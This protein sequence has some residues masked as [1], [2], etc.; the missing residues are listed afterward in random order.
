MGKKIRGDQQITSA[1]TILVVDDEE[2][3]LW[4][5]D[6]MLQKAGYSVIQA[7]NGEKVLKLLE[8]DIPDLILMDYRL[9]NRNG[10]QVAADVKQRIPTVPIIML[11]GY[12]EVGSAVEAMKIGVYDYVTKP[13]DIDDLLFTIKRCLEKQD[14]IEEVGRL[15]KAIEELERLITTISTRFINLS[16]NEIDSG[17]SEAVKEI[18]AFTD[19]DRS[20]AFVLSD[21]GTKIDDTY[22]WCAEGVKPQTQNL[23]GISINDEL[24][25][26]AKRL[27]EFEV[28][29]VP[30]VADLRPEASDEKEYFQAQDVQSLLAIPMTY[31]GSLA[32]FLRFDSTRANKKWTQGIIALL[33]VVGEIF[34]NALERKRT[35]VALQESE[36]RYRTVADFTYDWEY[37]LAPD[38]QFI[39]IS[40]S[41]ER[42][43]GYS[44]EEFVNDPGLFE[45]IIHPDD[46]STV[47]NHLGE[48]QSL[49]KSV[50]IDFRIITRRGE[51]RWISHVCQ[52]VYGADETY[53][54][55]RASNRDIS[56]R[57]QM[58]EELLKS[59]KMEAIATLAGGVAH[60]FNNA[61]MG[62][63]GNIELLKMDLPEEKRRDRYFEAMRGSGHRM[64]RLTD[65]LLAYAQGGKY[66]PKNLKLDAFVIQTL[67]I[68]QHDLSPEVRV[69]THF[70][71]DISHIKADNAQMQMVLSAI[72][73][74]SNE[75]IEDEGLI[76]ITAENKDINEDFTKQRPGLKPGYYV[77]LTIKDDGKGMDE[78]T[79]SGIFEPFF[80][81]K[82]Q[83]RGM[84]MAAVYGIVKNHHGWI[85][86]DSELGKGTLVQIY[87]PAIEIELKKPEKAEVEIATGSGTI[88]MIEDEDVV[89]E[90]TQAM[91]EW[92]GYRVMVAKTGKDAIHI[93]ETFDGQIDLALLDIKLPDIE[94]GKVYPL[95]MKARP[96]LKVVIFS[97]Y[98]IYGPARKIL[99]AGA[100]DFIQKPFSLATLSEKLNRN[101]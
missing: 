92:L 14:L 62:I 60:E 70:S 36:E 20:Y 49:E 2:D 91:L 9:P 5:T 57:K 4:A 65:Q 75:A 1:G 48:E 90:V 46:H 32:G 16:S 45:K 37:W 55:R 23:K 42:I 78:E 86:V 88:L 8:K 82:F 64:S 72:L 33:G 63:M 81:T 97:G 30:C 35:E 31:G 80:T 34:T 51:E 74:N 44:S 41:C 39:Y 56:K 17:I 21:N 68:L 11:T 89:I 53:L 85:Y 101:S 98:A 67:Q 15:R 87:L 18:G 47:I 96:D 26:F 6:T 10:L 66:Q 84:G 99:D 43:T 22:E 94:G 58:Q 95:I 83:G 59:R 19:V 76:R 54:G 61:L 28:V 79:I 71:K 93:A 13:V 12:A 27:K 100:Q 52:A 40:P 7:K 38:G 24:P 3:F 25:W 69:E 77:C 73:A 50:S 29:H